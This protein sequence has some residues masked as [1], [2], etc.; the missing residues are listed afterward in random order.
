MINLAE[1]LKG[2]RV[3]ITGGLGMIGS[4]IARKLVRF[5]AKVTLADACIEPYGSNM[6]NVQEI[7]NLISISITDI[8]DKESIKFL[9]KDKDIIFNLAGQVSHNDS[10]DNPFLDAEINYF[11]QLNV[12]ESVRR[13]NP[14]AVLLFPGSRLQFGRIESNPVDEKHP[15]RPRTPYALNKTA[16]ENMYL[17][18]HEIYGIPCTIFRIANPYGP[19][20]Q[21]KHSKY[22][23]VNWFVR[24]AME[25]KII[26]VFGD[27]EQ[28]RDYIYVDDLADAFLYASVEP[29][30]R[31]EVY[32]V[33]SGEGTRFKDM[34]ETI[35]DVIGDGKVEYVPWP[36]NYI[37]VETGDYVT[38]IRKICGAIQWKP[39]TKLREGIKLTFEYYKENKSYY[40]Q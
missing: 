7:S 17:F 4:T 14:E 1:R 40:W 22:S 2:K 38:D 21:M 16:A 20:S 10:I 32:N 8:R 18:Y 36:D 24:Q 30:C 12:L 3:L 23:I 19:R 13:Y 15:L 37:N 28:I 5:G 35:L 31:G 33:G 39:K 25:G 9:V 34:V 11:G 27:G 29:K 6:F 26:K